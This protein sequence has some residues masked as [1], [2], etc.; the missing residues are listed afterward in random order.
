MKF[1]V[2]T[3]RFVNTRYRE[4]FI[5]RAFFLNRKIECARIW[6]FTKRILICSVLGH[7]VANEPD[8]NRLFCLR[9]GI[10]EMTDR[11]S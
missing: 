5:G 2:R 8:G 4:D 6:L 9:C 1:S 11:K 7:T 3:L 10:Q